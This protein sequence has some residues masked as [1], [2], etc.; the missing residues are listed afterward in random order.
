MHQGYRA[1]GSFVPACVTEIMFVL[2]ST[3]PAKK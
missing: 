3:K 2:G 1:S